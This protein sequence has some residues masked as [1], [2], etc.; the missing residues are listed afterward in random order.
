MNELNNSIDFD[1]FV[2]MCRDTQLFIDLNESASVLT[3]EDCKTIFLQS[4]LHQRYDGTLR[5]RAQA[6]LARSK[7]S[8][9]FTEEVK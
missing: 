3:L 7:E 5:M 4:Q 8:S 9:H 1:E 2:S 6:S